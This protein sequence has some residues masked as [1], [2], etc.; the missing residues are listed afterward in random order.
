MDELKVRALI[1]QSDTGDR[2]AYRELLLGLEKHAHSFISR[3]LAP[4][5]NFPKELRS[6][7]VQEVLIAFH[8]THQTFDRSRPILPWIN[9][10]IRHKMI[11]F[12]RK[13]D[14]RILMSGMNW[15]I[16]GET[17]EGISSVD[18]VEI[19]E[20]GKALASLN[21]KEAELIRLAKVEGLTMEEMA[22]KLGL[23]ESNIK[24]SLFRA[25]KALRE[26]VSKK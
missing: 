15:E 6:D 21:E 1:L 24:V 4:Y 2:V 17:L 19:S 8:E 10:I 16:L 18:P 20:A 22:K 3:G 9:A 14:F 23:S 11:D 5:R 12:L 25:M 26:I 7:I 13:K